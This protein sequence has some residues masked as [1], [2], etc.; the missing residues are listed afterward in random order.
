MLAGES[1]EGRHCVQCA[2]EEETL[3]TSKPVGMAPTV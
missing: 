1:A 3:E 2:Q